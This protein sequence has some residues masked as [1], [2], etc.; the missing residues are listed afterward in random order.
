MAGSSL[1]FASIIMAFITVVRCQ[2]MGTE[3]VTKLHFFLHDILHDDK[4]TAV[5]VAQANSSHGPV[6]ATPFG[7]VYVIDDLLTEGPEPDSPLVGNAQ[8]FY[9]S[10]GQKTLTLLMGVD[11]EIT[12]GP[13]S[14]SSF[15][16]VSRNPVPE[17]R[18][19]LAV[20]GGRG[21]FRMARGFAELRTY[22]F[23]ITNGNAIIEYDVTLLHYE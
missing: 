17:P 9:L 16:V 4:P 18:R 11:F 21:K 15:S 5:L 19:E 10:S 6:S 8:G 22:S 20:V 7:S 13:F 2:S 3:T 23:N 14:G 12:A 1:L